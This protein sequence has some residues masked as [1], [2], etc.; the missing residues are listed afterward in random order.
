PYSAAAPGPLSTVR[1]PISSGLRS[2]ARLVK[3]TPRF[4]NAVVEFASDASTPVLSVRLSIGRP[5]TMISGW[6]LPLI[7]LTPRMVI[8]E[9]APGTPDV[10][11]TSTPATRPDSE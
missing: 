10:L 3:S 7:E 9:D 2:A 1:L 6:L 4:E 5:S 8:D 11:V